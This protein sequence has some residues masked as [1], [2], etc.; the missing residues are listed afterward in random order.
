MQESEVKGKLTRFLCGMRAYLRSQGGP[1]EKTLPPV[2]SEFIVWAGETLGGDAPNAEP[3]GAGAI[4]SGKAPKRATTVD[5]QALKYVGFCPAEKEADEDCCAI[6]LE[7]LG[8]AEA[9][10]EFGEPVITHCGHKYHAICFA[11]H[12]EA[13]AKPDARGLI[14][15]PWCPVC[16]SADLTA[17]FR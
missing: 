2:L 10:R 5:M 14:L 17:S 9:M 8:D 16:R 12:L 4:G 7:G 3:G 13:A 11:R 1:G 6:C 15:D